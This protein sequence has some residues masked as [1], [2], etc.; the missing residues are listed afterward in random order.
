M[1]LCFL[2]YL[3]VATALLDR[4]FNSQILRSTTQPVHSPKLQSLPE[5]RARVV[6]EGARSGAG[7]GGRAFE[8]RWELAA[9]GGGG[10][11]A[12]WLR[13][14]ELRNRPRAKARKFVPHLSIAKAG[15]SAESTPGYSSKVE[16]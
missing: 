14:W 2:S 3:K 7:P 13:F 15:S 12:E 9:R 8:L 5:P 1:T 16:D 4:S 11:R 6:G 10:Q